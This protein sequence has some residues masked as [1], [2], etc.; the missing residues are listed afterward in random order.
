MVARQLRV[1]RTAGQ[2]GSH[3]HAPIGRV[4]SSPLVRAV[5]TAEI[6][7]AEACGQQVS[8]EL[9]D[10]LAAEEP[11]TFALATELAEIGSD[12]LLVGH[13]PAAEV[14]V[15]HL[16]GGAAGLRAMRTATIAACRWDGR[17]WALD[18]VIER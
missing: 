18:S 17:A 6:V 4:I 15:R 9:R 16:C 8:V 7:L 3:G 2:G 11:P 10:E 5:E 14:L 1:A 13:Q 12:A